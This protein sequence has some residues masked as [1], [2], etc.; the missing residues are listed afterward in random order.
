MVTA[1]DDSI[2]KIYQSL[3]EKGM[4][5]KTIIIFT[6]DNGGWIAGASN[7]PLRGQKASGWEGGVRSPTIIWSPLLRL[8][9]PRTSSQLMHITDWLPTIYHVSGIYIIPT[10]SSGT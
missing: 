9:T 2:R 4:L 3:R 7:W 8:Q 5:S 1:L 6:S 10:N